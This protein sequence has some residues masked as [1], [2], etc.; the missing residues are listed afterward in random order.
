MRK[1]LCALAAML[2]GV[3][4]LGVGTANAAVVSYDFVFEFS[5]GDQPAGPAPWLNATF[6]DGGSAGAV[7]LTLSADG[8]VDK[9][10]VTQWYF[11]VEPFQLIS[12]SHDSGVMPTG[13]ASASNGFK[14]DGDGWFD[15]LILYMDPGD[16]FAAGLESVLTLTAAGLTADMFRALSLGDGNSPNG[17]FAAAEIRGIATEDCDCGKGSGWVAPIPIMGALP[18]LLSALGLLGLT[19][20][21]WR[22][23]VS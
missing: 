10:F 20:G 23:W 4:M 9:E 15:L 2:L 5:G 17:L 1:P 12:V 22:R 14:A 8:L 21:F 18:L 16:K 19:G 7:E 6:D 11:N 13:T 3:S